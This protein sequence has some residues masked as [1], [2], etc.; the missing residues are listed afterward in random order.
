V[1]QAAVGV[2]GNAPVEEPL[3]TGDVL[4]VELVVDEVLEAGRVERVEEGGVALLRG[5]V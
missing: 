5:V 3:Q 4:E 2:D 1:V